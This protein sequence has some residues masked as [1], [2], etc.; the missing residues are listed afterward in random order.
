M[1]VTRREKCKLENVDIELMKKALEAVLAK[2]NAKKLSDLEYIL[3]GWHG[4]IRFSKDGSFYVDSWG[5]ESDWEKIKSMIQD[6]YIA[7]AYIISL[8]KNGFKNIKLTVQE[9][10]TLCV[11]G[12]K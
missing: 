9:D 12:V 7:E 1:S 6:Q 2:Y 10:G 11:L 3:P 5:H 4:S 8:R